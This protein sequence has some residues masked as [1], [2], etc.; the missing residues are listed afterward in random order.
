[1]LAPFYYFLIYYLFFNL[2]LKCLSFHKCINAVLSSS[3]G[4]QDVSIEKKNFRHCCSAFRTVDG[5]Y[6]IGNTTSSS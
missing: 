4:I 1:M 2:I 3:L 6:N 5:E